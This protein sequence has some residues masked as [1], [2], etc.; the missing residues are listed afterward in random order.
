MSDYW[1]LPKTHGYGAQ[2][3]N[4]KG[5]AATFGYVAVTLVVTWVL[6]IWPASERVG[7]Q[8]W[9][10]VSWLTLTSALTAGFMWLS[11]AKTKGEWRWRWGEK[12]E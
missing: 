5:W 8:G 11:R 2:P 1:F 6:M 10:I 3:A 9:H 4:W 12:V 7:P